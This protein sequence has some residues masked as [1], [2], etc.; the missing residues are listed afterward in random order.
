MLHV[1]VFP[2]RSPFSLA[3]FPTS[4]TYPATLESMGFAKALVPQRRWCVGSACVVRVDVA[5]AVVVVVVVVM[6]VVVV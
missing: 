5:A 2:P 6:V 3:R 1:W 4:S